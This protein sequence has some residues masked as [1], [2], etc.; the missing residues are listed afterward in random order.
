[1]L[2]S[3]W[4]AWFSQQQAALAFQLPL[5]PEPPDTP[6]PKPEPEPEPE[7]EP[8][9]PPIFTP[10]AIANNA[11]ASV[12]NT[13]A[14]RVQ[15]QIYSSTQTIDMRIKVEADEHFSIAFEDR[16][17]DSITEVVRAIPTKR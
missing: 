9:P 10:Q 1:M 2:W 8:T 4:W 13:P 15:S 3:N 12:A 11:A 6:E 5:P 17:I 7:P 14:A 16:I